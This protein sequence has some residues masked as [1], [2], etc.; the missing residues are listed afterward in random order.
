MRFGIDSMLGRV[1]AR[2]LMVLFIFQPVYVAMGMELDPEAQSAVNAGTE[3][4]VDGENAESENQELGIMN[5]ESDGTNDG[6]M[7]ATVVESEAVS[8][9][10]ES[11][12][13]ESGIINHEDGDGV[14]SDN[15]DEGQDVTGVTGG[16]GDHGPQTMEDETLQPTIN[17]PQSTSEGDEATTTASTTDEVL[18]V[19]EGDDKYPTQT[20]P[21]IGEKDDV[22]ASTSNDT[23]SDVASTSDEE[24]LEEVVPIVQNAENKYNFGEGDCTLIADG[25]FYCVAPTTARIAEGDP[26]VYAEK[27]REG[28]REI[29]YFDGVEIHRIT[30]NA[31][32]DFAPVFDDDTLRIVW[33]A[34]IGDRMQIMVHDV[35]TNTTRQI[36]SGREN[37]SNP[38]IMG[39]TVVW[40]E[41]VDTNWEVMVTNVDN[42][43]GV[44]EIERLTDNAVH[45]MF[46]QLYDGLVTW[47][48][49]KGDSWE[50]VVYDMRTKRE[51]ALEKNED[52]KY[53][54]P[55]FVLLFDSKH[56]N[57]DV[58]TIGYDLDTG[59][60]MELG[61]KANP[62]PVA[63]ASPKEEIPDAPVVVASS[64]AVKVKDEVGGSGDG[65][66]VV[67]VG[68]E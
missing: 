2:I 7:V 59:E 52:T 43:G 20:S 49:E 46:P 51:Q 9:S 4:V 38:D 63:P 18:D 25:E 17:N 1:V 27:D 19:G 40:Q 31:Y 58:E 8:A 44:F 55:R 64:T 37:S 68:G 42:D 54:N 22:V 34:N 41:W 16:S 47:Q 66:G 5:N 24:I 12:H 61:T 50:V 30:N 53:E 11:E 26:R 45:D 60:M 39:D 36:T 28:D 23:L 29:L 15:G 33:Q 32:D 3:V 67:G 6:D 13:Q 35:P 56:E 62:Q 57:G 10:A 65:D 14:T 48:H 21:Y